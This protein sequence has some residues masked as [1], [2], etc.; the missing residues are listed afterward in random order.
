[1]EQLSQPAQAILQAL[2]SVQPTT[3]WIRDTRENTVVFTPSEVDY[4]PLRLQ[5][6]PYVILLQDIKLINDI[7]KFSI[8]PPPQYPFPRQGRRGLEPL[9]EDGHVDLVPRPTTITNH[10]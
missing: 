8:T 6:Q 9:V 3:R 4:N 7:I 1:M 5:A 2:D 10:V